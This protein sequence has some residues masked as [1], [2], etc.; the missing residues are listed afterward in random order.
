MMN[1]EQ[2]IAILTSMGD[3]ALMNAMSANGIDAEHSESYKADMGAEVSEGLE[4]WSERDVSIPASQRPQ[5]VN[6]EALFS[7]A[8]AEME[9][10]EILY[11]LEPGCS[12]FA[13]P[14]PE[15]RTFI[16]ELRDDGR[17]VWL[18]AAA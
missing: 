5:L 6:T 12:L 18:F 15:T 14:S 11:I 13:Q 3:D 2:M 10:E 8:R 7:A 9:A 17:K 1:R 16:N 4:S